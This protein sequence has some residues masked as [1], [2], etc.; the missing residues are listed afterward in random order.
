MHNRRIDGSSKCSGDPLCRGTFISPHTNVWEIDL[1]KSD[2]HIFSM[3]HI[4]NRNIPSY[5][6]IELPF[7]FAYQG[8]WWLSRIQNWT[9]C[10]SWLK[11]GGQKYPPYLVYGD[12]AGSVLNAGQLRPYLTRYQIKSLGMDFDLILSAPLVACTRVAAI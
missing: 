1:R 6:L 7:S 3:C 4:F 12:K 8:C 2:P 5:E 10:I 9:G 11:Y